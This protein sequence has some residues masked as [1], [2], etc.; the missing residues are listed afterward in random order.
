MAETISA[1]IGLVTAQLRGVF[2][3]VLYRLADVQPTHS[4]D[5]AC[6]SNVN[7]VCKFLLLVGFIFSYVS[8]ELRNDRRGLVI[9]VAAKA[10]SG[11]FNDSFLIWTELI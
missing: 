1:L 3:Q 10:K 11:S 9:Y 8:P 5:A 7:A 2:I 4:P 6:S